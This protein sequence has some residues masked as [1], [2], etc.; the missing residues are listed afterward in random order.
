MCPAADQVDL[1]SALASATLSRK[2]E[3][4]LINPNLRQQ[5]EPPWIGHANEDWIKTPMSPPKDFR[6]RPLIKPQVRANSC[7]SPESCQAV[8]M[9]CD[10]I[11]S[12]VLQTPRQ[13]QDEWQDLLGSKADQVK[14]QV[15][16]AATEEATKGEGQSRSFSSW[17]NWWR[18]TVGTDDYMKFLSTQ[19]TDYLGVVFHFYNSDD[20]DDEED[21]AQTQSKS[22]RKSRKQMREY[23]ALVYDL[24]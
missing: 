17:L 5:E 13:L 2:P 1:S 24:P 9:C 18:N 23:V 3:E 16:G 21:A 15:L 20:D 12:R 19:E 4:R 7:M 14:A 11:T 22:T 10:V 8:L 6:G